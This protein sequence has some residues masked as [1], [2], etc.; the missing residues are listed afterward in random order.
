MGDALTKSGVMHLDDNAE[1]CTSTTTLPR[2]VTGYS[3]A[4]SL[5]EVCVG[6]LYFFA[7]N[8][9]DAE[10]LWIFLLHLCVAGMENRDEGNVSKLK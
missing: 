7:K 5:R 1:S 3:D 9:T 8:G 10:E 2:C 4:S 6:I